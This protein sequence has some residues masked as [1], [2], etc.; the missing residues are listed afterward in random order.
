MKALLMHRDRDFDLQRGLPWNESV[1]TQD[2]EL[3]T[4]LQ[5]MAAG[6]KFLLDVARAAVLS[7]L[8]SDVDTVLYRQR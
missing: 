5:T 3:N 6:D 8:Q 2:L 7:G 1:L 4:L